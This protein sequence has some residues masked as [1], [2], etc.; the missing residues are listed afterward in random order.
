MLYSEHIIVDEEMLSTFIN[1][2]SNDGNI[3]EKL[4]SLTTEL[5]ERLKVFGQT[6]LAL[7]SVQVFPPP[8]ITQTK[9]GFKS[10]KD[11]MLSSAY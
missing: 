11:G 10:R 8:L 1:N 9:K 2:L 4:G 3:L 7:N 5:H 6:P